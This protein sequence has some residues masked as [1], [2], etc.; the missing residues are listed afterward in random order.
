MKHVSSLMAALLII[1]YVFCNNAYSEIEA[2]SFSAGP[3]AG[4]YV[5]EDDQDIHN[6]PVYGLSFGYNYTDSIGFEG[7]FNY[8]QTDAS[9]SDDNVQV[10]VYRIDA[11][12]HFMPDSKFV[13]YIAVGGGAVTLDDNSGSDT[14]AMMN[15]GAGL[16][17]FLSKSFALR[18]DIRHIIDFD[19]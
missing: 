3:S 6:G 9:S 5:F 4:W 1:V 17:F 12:Y 7:A 15:Y 11:L 10:H 16:K 8:I 14:G 13:P 19:Y 2:G 18:S